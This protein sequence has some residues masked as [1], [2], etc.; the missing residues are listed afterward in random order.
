MTGVEPWVGRVAGRALS[1]LGAEAK[2]LKQ[3]RQ[4]EEQRPLI[5]T[6]V[7]DRSFE[8][9]P[10][11][12]IRGIA[13][14]LESPDFE[15]VALQLV[16]ARAHRKAG[17]EEMRFAARE[18]IRE[19]LRLFAGPPPDQLIALTDT[20]FS[21]LDVACDVPVQ[22]QLLYH[23]VM[24]HVA[25]MA[26][27]N[28]RLL[29]R[30][31]ELNDTHQRA[32][33][34]RRQVRALH[35]EL[36]MPHTGEGR[37]V[38]WQD[39]YVVPDF[40][41]EHMEG[42]D[43]PPIVTWTEPGEHRVILGD[44]GAGKSTLAA[45]LAHDCAGDD[46]G[47]VP[48]LVVLRDLADAL[49]TGER[50]VV[51]H[52]ATVARVPYHVDISADAIEYLLLNGQ[53]AVILDGFDELTDVALR[54]R[55]TELI[56]GFVS[57]YP[58]VPVLATSR[59]I[60]YADA[61]LDRRY[62]RT[63]LIAPF[64]PEQVE[65][66]A[67]KWFGL[68]DSLPAPDRQRLCEAFLRESEA[69][70]D[71]RSNPLLLSLLCSMYAT[72][73]FI[74]RNRAQIYERCAVMV[75]DRWDTMRG[76]TVPVEFESK[77]RGAVQQLAWEMFTRGDEPEM[78]QDKVLRSLM[79]YLRAKH[80]DEDDARDLAERFLAFCAG[81]AWVLV[82]VGSTEAQPIYGF[83]HRTF[84]EFF[85]AEHLV[86]N[87]PT[88]ELVWH[89]LR[90]RLTDSGWEVVAQLAVQLLDRNLEDGAET[91]LNLALDEAGH[92][93][94]VLAFAARACG[95]VGLSPKLLERITEA[96]VEAFLA[97][98]LEKRTA[99]WVS[100]ADFQR[101]LANDSPLDALMYRSLRGNRP[102]IRRALQARLISLG[103]AH[104]DTALYLALQIGR[105]F[106]PDQADDTWEEL[107][108]QLQESLSAEF[109]AWDLRHP[110]RLLNRCFDEPDLV[111][112]IVDRFGAAAF[113]LSDTAIHGSGFPRVSALLTDSEMAEPGLAFPESAHRL[114]ERLL[115]TPTPWLPRDRWL[116]EH[117][118]IHVGRSW[119][120][121]H[122]NEKRWPLEGEDA[123]TFTILTLPYQESNELSR[124]FRV[125]GM[126]A[127]CVQFLKRWQ[128]REFRVVA[129]KG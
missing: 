36:R 128:N 2:Y 78:L 81:R 56:R 116:D 42:A 14:Y 6:L 70:E 120:M 58:L 108:T 105:R 117:A 80:F 68:N 22:D 46:S 45:K 107:E 3:L 40:L 73:Q 126:P 53:A 72:E 102:Y 96:A 21:A 93:A 118:R 111:D 65:T 109:E 15:Q 113:Y 103:Q 16:I 37:A 85:V 60:G 51:E 123:A 83:A 110:W 94:S 49:R 82:E 29:A 124:A 71:L 119:Q 86:R 127:E 30:V 129:P 95:Q 75:F 76:I 19:G 38:S 13:R 33:R 106:I 25:G 7:A 24:A 4:L 9:L 27:R 61:P 84:L 1:W 63:R 114:R 26:A 31:T 122:L 91:L 101:I 11:E 47:K 100:D 43:P 55:L 59:R 90:D 57:L 50:T 17:M 92:E 79:N 35:S 104:D 23:P 12:T 34:L 98:P 18:E 39:L 54:R 88:P 112:T 52:L 121:L 28:G 8:G 44:P 10:P 48:F 32:D 67:R 64:N 125:A 87:A 74:P 89:K 99:F 41:P 97:I 115:A 62:F 69:I 20:V 77:V 5:P 66:Y